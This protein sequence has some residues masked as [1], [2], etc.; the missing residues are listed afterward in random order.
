MRMSQKSWWR[1]NRNSRSFHKLQ[2][3][4]D[5]IWFKFDFWFHFCFK[6][7]FAHFFDTQVRTLAMQFWV[8]MERFCMV[9]ISH[10]RMVQQVDFWLSRFLLKGFCPELASCWEKTVFSHK[11]G[12]TLIFEWGF[13]YLK[14][15]R[16]N[17]YYCSR[18]KKIVENGWLYAGNPCQGTNRRSRSRRHGRGELGF[19]P[20]LLFCRKCSLCCLFHHQNVAIPSWTYKMCDAWI[21]LKLLKRHSEKC[22]DWVS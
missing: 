11:L 15:L 18:K 2:C 5:I 9:F 10:S 14:K 8:Y 3:E 6:F 19:T 22:C 1:W 7:W 20:G 17:K 13:G 21:C 12:F 16:V 4:V